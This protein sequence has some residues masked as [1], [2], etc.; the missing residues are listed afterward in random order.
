MW[1]RPTQSDTVTLFD[2]SPVDRGTLLR[3]VWINNIHFPPFGSI[4]SHSI[5]WSDSAAQYPLSLSLSIHSI[6]RMS[7]VDWLLSIVSP[8]NRNAILSSW[9][10]YT[11]D[12]IFVAT[13]CVFQSKS[14]QWWVLLLLHGHIS[15]R[16]VGCL[17]WC[18]LS[19]SLLVTAVLFQM[20]LLLSENSL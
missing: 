3:W 13:S 15:I 2:G 20:M 14:G 18:L 4:K 7:S 9:L 12:L 10:L 16:L 8:V 6:L 19:T 11:N 5:S 1:P 17:D